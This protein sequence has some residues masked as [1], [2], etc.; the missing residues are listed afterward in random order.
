M[1]A[2][3]VLVREWFTVVD[4]SALVCLT[5]EFIISFILKMLI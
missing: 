3:N 1:Y 2:Q 4:I 5:A